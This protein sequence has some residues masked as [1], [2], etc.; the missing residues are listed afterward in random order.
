MSRQSAAISKL[1]RRAE[2]SPLMVTSIRVG[3]ENLSFN[4]ATAAAGF[5]KCAA[6]HERH[7]KAS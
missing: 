2:V 4:R 3:V 5:A 6:R 7:G 1:S